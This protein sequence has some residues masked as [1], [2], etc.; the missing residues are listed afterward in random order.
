M[1]KLILTPYFYCV[2]EF[3]GHFFSH[4]MFFID[5]KL[6]KIVSQA[7]CLLAASYLRTNF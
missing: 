4:N 5:R 2:K 6:M 7:D 3:L 1:G